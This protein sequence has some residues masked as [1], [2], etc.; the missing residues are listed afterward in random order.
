M[1]TSETHEGPTPAGGVRSIMYYQDKDGQPA[2]KAEAVRAEG[3]E[4]DAAGEVIQRTYFVLKGPL[5][6]FPDPS[7]RLE[8][9]PG[10]KGGVI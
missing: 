9:P 3:V 2:E 8:R 10:G 7:S 5:A 4:L 1:P 6:A